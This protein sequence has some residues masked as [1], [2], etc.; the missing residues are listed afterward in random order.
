METKLKLIRVIDGTGDTQQ[1]FTPEDVKATAE[2]RSLFERLTGKGYAAFD[3]SNKGREKQIREFSEVGD[4]T[5][6]ARFAGG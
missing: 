3:V 4:E 1:R 6:L 5:I 2:A